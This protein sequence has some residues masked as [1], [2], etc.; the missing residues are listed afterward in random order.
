MEYLLSLATLAFG[1]RPINSLDAPE[2]LAALRRIERRGTHNTAHRLRAF[3]SETFCMAIATGRARG[4]PAHA[5]REALVK[6]K[7][8]KRAAIVEAK[9][10]G[11]LLRAIDGLEG[12]APENSPRLAIAQLNVCASGRAAARRMVRVRSRRRSA[13]VGHSGGE[14]EDA[15]MRA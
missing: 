11:Q 6:P 12:G 10:F 4:D 15:Q 14:N 9:P 1:E 13:R 7:A 5:L 2:I 8:Q 3:V